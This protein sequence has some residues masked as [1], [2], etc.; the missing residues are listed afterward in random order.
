MRRP[1]VWRKV[2]TKLLR[3]HLPTPAFL[4]SGFLKSDDQLVKD[5]KDVRLLRIITSEVSAECWKDAQDAD[6]EL[7]DPKLHKYFL[8]TCRLYETRQNVLSETDSTSPRLSGLL[9][10]IE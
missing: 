4:N 3:A 6:I 5:T 9:D 1:L 10:G 8:I 2:S 7:G